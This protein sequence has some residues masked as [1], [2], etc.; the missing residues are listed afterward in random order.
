MFSYELITI[1]SGSPYREARFDE[2]FRLIADGVDVTQKWVLNISFVDDETM[3]RLNLEY[4]GKDSTTDVLSFHYFEDFSECSEDEVVWECIF[5]HARITTQSLEYGHSMVEEFEILLIHSI[6]HI[7]GY[8]HED[9]ADF[10]EMFAIERSIRMK[11]WL[12]IER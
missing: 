9:D 7:L 5:S 11:M 1:P 4:R 12:N 10:E 3:R 2:I 6:L 8:D